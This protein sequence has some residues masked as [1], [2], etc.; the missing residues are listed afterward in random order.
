MIS[1]Q[2][3]FGSTDLYQN[4][5]LTRVGHRSWNT[6]FFVFLQISLPV[7]SSDSLI[8]CLKMAVLHR[9]ECRSKTAR[10]ICTFL[11][12]QTKAGFHYRV[13]RSRVYLVT[14]KLFLVCNFGLRDQSFKSLGSFMQKF[15]WCYNWEWKYNLGGRF[16]VI[17]KRLWPVKCYRESTV[18]TIQQAA[19]N[20]YTQWYNNWARLSSQR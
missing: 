8:A 4:L 17:W 20:I 3:N 1:K 18:G 7:V 13:R 2:S 5:A 14:K 19:V 16:N 12:F 11:F 10:T 9:R 6:V 15:S